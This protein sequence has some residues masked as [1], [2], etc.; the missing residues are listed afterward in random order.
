MKRDVWVVSAEGGCAHCHEAKGSGHA[1]DCV[2]R[3][4]TV[5]VRVSVELVI[6]EPET[7]DAGM[8]E[9]FHNESSSCAS[10]VASE[11]EQFFDVMSKEQSPACPCG[12]VSVA[13][14]R[15]ASEENE[16]L[17]GLAVADLRG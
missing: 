17:Q 6:A 11:L 8:I 13:Y 9:F 14:V 2:V 12:F 4:R 5:V 3:K 7:W 10:N 15:E 1:V 16:L